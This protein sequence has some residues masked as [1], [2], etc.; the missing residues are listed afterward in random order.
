MLTTTGSPVKHSQEILAL[1]DAVLLPKQVSVI[2]LPSHQ[3]GDDE[4]SRGNVNEATKKT[5]MRQFFAGSPFL[6]PLVKFPQ[7]GPIAAGGNPTG[8]NPRWPSGS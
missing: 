2:H 8:F 3:K 4:I 6:I 5:A 7:G 1:L